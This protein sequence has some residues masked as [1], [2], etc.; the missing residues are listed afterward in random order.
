MKL[1]EDIN[2]FAIKV[3][4]YMWDEET[5][6]EYEQPVYLTI[7]T[8]TRGDSGVPLNLIMFTENITSN[9]RV[10]DTYREAEEYMAK[11]CSNSPCFENPR[12]VKIRFGKENKWEEA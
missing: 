4:Y 7:D 6:S 9:L 3:D 5:D 11:K 1:L 12:V 2:I 10:F 8:E